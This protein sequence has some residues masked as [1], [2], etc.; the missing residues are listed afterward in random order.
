MKTLAHLLAVSGAA[1]QFLIHAGFMLSAARLNSA[2]ANVDLRDPQ[3]MDKMIGI[4]GAVTRQMEGAWAPF[5]WATGLA[6][7]GVSIFIVS[8]TYLRYRRRWSFWF[9]C[10]YGGLLTLLF[11]LGTVFGLVLL[12]HAL[13]HQQEFALTACQAQPS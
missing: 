7:L 3:D 13:S 2:I 1:S 12:I 6:M 5:L 11:P 4:V 9:A 10:I 8:L